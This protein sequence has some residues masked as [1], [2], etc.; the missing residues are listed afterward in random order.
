MTF[1]PAAIQSGVFDPDTTHSM[2]LALDEICRE[3][4]LDLNGREREV[5]ATRI[6]DLVR[7]GLRDPIQLRERVLREAATDL[8]E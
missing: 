6:V 7:E 1:S 4:K 2:A 3:L 5:L 8:G